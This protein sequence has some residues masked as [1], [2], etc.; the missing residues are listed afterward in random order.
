M[1]R[2]DYV[3]RRDGQLRQW[4]ENVDQHLRADPA[5][6]GVEPGE[7]AHLHGYVVAFAEALERATGAATRTAPAVAEKDGA[8]AALE[9][10][11]REV[12][13]QIRRNRGVANADRAALGL[14][15]A[16][17]IPTRIG[18][19]VTAPLLAVVA[20]CPGVHTLRYADAAAPDRRGKPAGALGLQLFVRLTPRDAEPDDGEL[21][22]DP[23]DGEYVA[24]VTRQ[25][26][27]VTF[28]PDRAGMTAHYHA[29]WQTRT[30]LVGP[31]SAVE[32]MVVV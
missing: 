22:A 2:H 21:G 23:A 6:Y 14:T 8:R 11:L 28:K 29:R 30:G 31:W 32:T 3:P 9:A 12:A 5:R 19:P 4:A 27:G 7:A 10:L 20:A 18:A 25:P 16:D 15:I 17:R 24:F 13:G 1:S 26:F